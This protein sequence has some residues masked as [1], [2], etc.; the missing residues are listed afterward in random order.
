MATYKGFTICTSATPK[1]WGPIDQVYEQNQIDCT[2]TDAV[3]GVMDLAGHKHSSTYD[4]YKNKVIDSNNGNVGIGITN[5]SSKLYVNGGHITVVE[6]SVSSVIGAYTSASYLHSQASYPLQLGSGNNN[7]VTILSNGN[8]GIN[9]NSP[10]STLCLNG[11]LCVGTNENLAGG[12]QIGSST[13]G[14]AYLNGTIGNGGYFHLNCGMPDNGATFNIE[15][16][17]GMS[18]INLTDTNIIIGSGTTEVTGILQVDSVLNAQNNVEV[19]GSLIVLGAGTNTTTLSVTSASDFI[20]PVAFSNI[21]SSTLTTGSDSV[22]AS[23]YNGYSWRPGSPTTLLNVTINNGSQGMVFFVFNYT[24][25]PLLIGSEWF[26]PSDDGCGNSL[27]HGLLVYD[28]GAWRKVGEGGIGGVGVR[29][30]AFPNLHS[31]A[32]NSAAIGAGLQAGAL[33]INGDTLGIVH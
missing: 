30:V 7:I 8:V 9:Y 1:P 13:S 24:T 20:G 32:N 12:F 5:A 2:V 22:D 4:Q 6:N 21:K 19:D 33:Y 10:L 18:S 27:A 23:V 17:G 28:N 26:E 11:G 31:Y 3:G 14:P 25:Y 15:V 16:D 29:D